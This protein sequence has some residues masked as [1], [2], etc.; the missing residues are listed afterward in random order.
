MSGFTNAV[1]LGIDD[2]NDVMVV[3]HDIEIGLRSR[4][5][6][7]GRLVRDKGR[8]H[9]CGSIQCLI[10]V[11]KKVLHASFQVPRLNDSQRCRLNRQWQSNRHCE[12]RATK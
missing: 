7:L 11:A 6:D 8:L 3:N 1:L 9:Y 10:E 5:A 4:V 2:Q 12:E